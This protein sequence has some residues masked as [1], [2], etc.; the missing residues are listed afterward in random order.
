MGRLSELDAERAVAALLQHA[1]DF[2]AKGWMWGT[3]GNLSVKLNDSPLTI[4]ISGSGASKG[5]MQ[6]A[7]LEV[8]PAGERAKLKWLGEGA[9]KPSAETIIHQAVYERLPDIGA[10]Y[11]VHTVASTALS[12]EAAKLG[13]LAYIDVKNL[14]MLK[15][16]D[17]PWRGG[18][19]T[20][21][22]PVIP[23]HERMDVLA[24]GF[25][26][27]IGK[28]LSAPI[29]VAAGH[30]ITVWGKTPEETRNRIEIAEFIF[31]TL[32]EQAKAKLRAKNFALRGTARKR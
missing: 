24:Q 23:N 6:Y 12:L 17:I 16:W 3:A 1:R 31:H 9:R 7:D 32:W 19:I 8:L 13:S 14:E 29:I 15:G 26:K 25:A 27:L 10:V 20:A 22:I 21:A 4:A 30:G 18:T 2:H 5:E 11:H 28:G